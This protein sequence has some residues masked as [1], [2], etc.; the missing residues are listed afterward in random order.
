MNR[1]A[2]IKKAKISC[3]LHRKKKTCSK[4]D[5]GYDY[6]YDENLEIRIIIKTR[7][8]THLSVTYEL[9]KTD[10]QFLQERT[11]CRDAQ[12][13]YCTRLSLNLRVQLQRTRDASGG[14]QAGRQ[15]LVLTHRRVYNNTFGLFVCEKC[16]PALLFSFTLSKAELC[17]RRVV[18]L[19]R[20]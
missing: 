16:L 6:K 10:A 18:S 8:G 14:R 11:P 12:K 7:K 15:D 17:T 20:K 1:S 3:V 4:Y 9:I 5:D 19:K 2:H 13:G